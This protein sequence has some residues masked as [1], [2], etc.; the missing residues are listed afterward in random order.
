VRIDLTAGGGAGQVDTIV[1][2]ASVGD[3]VV[4]PGDAGRA[5]V[6]GL[7]ATTEIT[8]WRRPTAR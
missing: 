5:F 3:A 8:G 7:A 1:V 6:F 2:N 4:V